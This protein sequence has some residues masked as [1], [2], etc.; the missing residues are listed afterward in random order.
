M[1][2]ANPNDKVS[3]IILV[4]TIRIYVFPSFLTINSR[5][6]TVNKDDLRNVK[7]LL[8]CTM[9][10]TNRNILYVQGF[11]GADFNYYFIVTGY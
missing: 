1:L 7:F 8:S 10:V 11:I 9:M 3:S 6:S 5:D 2:T 4:A